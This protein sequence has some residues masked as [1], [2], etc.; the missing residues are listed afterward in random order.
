MVGAGAGERGLLVAAGGKAWEGLARMQRE[1]GRGMV[2]T[3]RVVKVGLTVGVE[4]G[5]AEVGGRG[6]N[7]WRTPELVGLSGVPWMSVWMVAR[8]SHIFFP[9]VNF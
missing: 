5:L 4:M 8:C 6:W 1:A 3:G 9:T 7:D 2:G